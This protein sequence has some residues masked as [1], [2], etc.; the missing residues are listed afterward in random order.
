MSLLWYLIP[1]NPFWE[2]LLCH[3]QHHANPHVA[4]NKTLRVESTLQLSTLLYSPPYSTL[5]PTLLSTLLTAAAVSWRCPRGLEED[6]LLLLEGGEAGLVLGADTGHQVRTSAW[7]SS[8]RRF[9]SNYHKGR[10]AI[11]HYANVERPWGQ[12][13]FSIVSK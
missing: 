12:R 13:P 3:Q 7:K 11:R 9:V 4:H 6:L 10:A 8:I 2:A 5:H 1:K